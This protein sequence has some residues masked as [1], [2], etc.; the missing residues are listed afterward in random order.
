MP[1]AEMVAV[2]DQRKG[3]QEMILKTVL[4]RNA[5]RPTRAHRDDAGLDLYAKTD[6]VILPLGRK[7]IGTGVHMAIPVGYC[8]LVT[9]KSG[10]A[11]KRGITCRGTVDAGYTGEIKATLFN[12]TILPKR[13]RRGQKITQI[14]IVPIETPDIVVVNSL[15]DTERGSGGFGSSG[16]W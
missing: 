5:V 16:L 15:A 8:G 2:R 3:E 11:H 13:I 12:H 1:A 9:S 10:I 7:T 4:D 6:A 14:V